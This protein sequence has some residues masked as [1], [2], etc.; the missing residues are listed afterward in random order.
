M[1]GYYTYRSPEDPDW[2]VNILAGRVPM[3]FGEARLC[4]QI[5][6]GGIQNDISIRELE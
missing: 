6:S 5:K 1:Q 2:G 3:G 4:V